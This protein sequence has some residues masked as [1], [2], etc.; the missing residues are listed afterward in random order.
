MESI[1]DALAIVF[2]VAALVFGTATLVWLASHLTL[3][4]CR[5]LAHLEFLV[6]AR[7]GAGSAS[8]A[9]QSARAS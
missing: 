8:S 2:T 1:T 7:A 9:S 4:A 5:R 3:G 6:F